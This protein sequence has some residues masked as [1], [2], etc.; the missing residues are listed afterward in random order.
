MLRQRVLIA[1]DRAASTDEVLPPQFEVVA[2]VRSNDHQALSRAALKLK[3]DIILI[4]IAMAVRDGFQAVKE[5]VRHLQHTRIVF[6][7]KVD[8]FGPCGAK[9]PSGVAS[10]LE[11]CGFVTKEPAD[12]GASD[13]IQVALKPDDHSTPA[14]QSASFP[15]LHALS[16]S[17]QLEP[18][19]REY[20]VLALLAA[21]HPM[22]QI[23]YRL[24]ITY[25]T[26]T[27]HKYRMMEKLGIK[28]NAGLMTY[29]LRRNLAAAA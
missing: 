5:I 7:P 23:A 17:S 6:Y 12:R 20:E 19:H 1:H 29:A 26:V 22:K 14:T 24:G 21:G 8:E 3:P 27:F 13:A 25:R 15:A 18:T 10:A 28:T 16:T 2:T 11:V 9:S 4:D